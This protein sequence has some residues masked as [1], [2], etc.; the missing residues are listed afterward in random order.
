M[1]YQFVG[2]KHTDQTYQHKCENKKKID[3]AFDVPDTS[4]VN[5]VRPISY[6]EPCPLII[7]CGRVIKKD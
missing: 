5:V 1:P 6:R 2:R 7:I 3:I 4:S